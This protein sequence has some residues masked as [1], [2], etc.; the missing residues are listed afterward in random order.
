MLKGKGR[1]WK[2]DSKFYIYVPKDIA[3]DSQ[4]PLKENKGNVEIEI[5]SNGLLVRPSATES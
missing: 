4:F 2:T 3:T 1:F 5:T